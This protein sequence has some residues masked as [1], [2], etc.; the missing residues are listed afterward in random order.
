MIRSTFAGF[1]A[2]GR[3]EMATSR[4][5]DDAFL[6]LPDEGYLLV[7]SD[8]TV[9]FVNRFACERLDLDPSEVVGAPLSEW[10]PELAEIAPTSPR[11]GGALDLTTRWHG[12]E[13]GVRL[14]ATDSGLGWPCA[15]G[16]PR[17]RVRNCGPL[18]GLFESSPNLWSSR[19]LNR[20]GRPVLSSCTSMRLF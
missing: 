2:R 10:W 16:H 3:Q 15:M 11:H 5:A 7:D 1:G 20:L 18:A 6:F 12:N 4:T 14:F 19:P 8:G 13:I 9:Q 17:H